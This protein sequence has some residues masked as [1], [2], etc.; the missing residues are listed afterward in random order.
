MAMRTKKWMRIL[1][2]TLLLMVGM[3][4]GYLFLPQFYYS[5]TVI[6]GETALT[7]EDLLRLAKV[8]VRKNIY[9]IDIKTAQKNIKQLPTV[10]EVK[11]S[12]KFPKTLVFSV[13]DCMEVAA[14]SFEGGF[15][16]I[17]DEGYVIRI[18]QNVSEVKRPIIS[19]IQTKR[20]K[21]GEQIPVENEEQ[22]AFVMGLIAGAQNARLMENISEV[23]MSQLDDVKMTTINGITVLLGE[24]KDLNYK[25]LLLNQILLDLHAQRI[26]Y[27]IIDMRY[28]S[29]P[30]YRKG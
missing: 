11:I 12:R 24:G 28:D 15:A 23:N 21:V 6:L 8:N 5:K 14:V 13:L 18:T 27:G 2:L 17:D 4:A 9:L 16:I 3:A 7:R 1:V 22:F 19:G 10:K 26:N 29:H 20:I 25:M 30:V